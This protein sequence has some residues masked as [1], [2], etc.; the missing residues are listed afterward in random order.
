MEQKGRCVHCR[1]DIT[2]PDSY[3]DGDHIK[4]GA[5]GTQHRLV[6]TGTNMRLVIA[7]VAPLREELHSNQQRILR[8]ENELAAARGSLGIGANGLGIGV[9]YILARVAWE[10][11][12]LTRELLINAAGIAA[13]TGIA[14]ELA[15]FLF[16]AKRKLLNQ[17]STELRLIRDETKELQ[18]KIREAGLRR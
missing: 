2:V 7:D 8:L 3:A 4:C 16:L 1:T 13:A 11:Q 12:D 14:L 6:R 9:I 10:D 18:R 15:N 5:C 17:I